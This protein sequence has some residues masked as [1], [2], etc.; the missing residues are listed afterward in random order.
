MTVRTGQPLP[1]QDLQDRAGW[2]EHDGK[3]RTGGTAALGT[4]V[5]GCDSRGRTAKPRQDSNR[6][7]SG[8]DSQDRSERGQDGQNMTAWTGKLGQDNRDKTTRKGQPEQESQSMTARKGQQ[9]KGSQERTART[10]QSEQ[11]S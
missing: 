8:Q 9:G 3:D 2:S 10:R 6:G 4:R 11:D 5:M 7:Q 1:R